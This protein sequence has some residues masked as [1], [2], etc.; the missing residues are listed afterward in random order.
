MRLH[1]KG[2]QQPHLDQRVLYLATKPKAIAW[3]PGAR[4]GQDFQAPQPPPPPRP[5]RAEPMDGENKPAGL[6][7][8]GCTTARLQGSLGGPRIQTWSQAGPG[9]CYTFTWEGWGGH[10][11]ARACL[12]A[13]AVFH[14]KVPP[15]SAHLSSF[16]STFFFFFCSTY[17]SELVGIDLVTQTSLDLPTYVKYQIAP[18]HRLQRLCSS[19]T[20][21]FAGAVGSVRLEGHPSR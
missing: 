6:S 10:A 1:D 8:E 20:I 18:G 9:L 12:C 11:S 17:S 19:S 16:C 3:R 7:L 14:D 13:R 2:R 4:G 5:C 21:S 15:R